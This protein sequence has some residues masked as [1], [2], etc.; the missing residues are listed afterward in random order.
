MPP[1]I[2]SRS[3]RCQG[4]TGSSAGGAWVNRQ[5]VRSTTN[6]RTLIPIDLC[7]FTRPTRSGPSDSGIMTQP[8]ANAHS[9]NPGINQCS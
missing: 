6:K 4:G 1:A 5:S 2:T 8:T 7:Q 9:I 3:D